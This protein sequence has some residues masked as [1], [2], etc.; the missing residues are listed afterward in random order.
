MEGA[1]VNPPTLPKVK[2]KLELAVLEKVLISA[3]AKC[4]ADSGPI[5]FFLR[6]L[7]VDTD[8]VEVTATLNRLAADGVLVYR[9][10]WQSPG[11]VGFVF[12]VPMPEVP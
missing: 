8:I 5:D 2:V 6:R 11:K 1:A 7:G 12:A 3:L 4:P 9:K 10:A